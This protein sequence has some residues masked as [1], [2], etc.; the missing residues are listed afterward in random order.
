M[1]TFDSG[2]VGGSPPYTPDKNTPTNTNEPYLSFIDYILSQT[3][4]PRTIT[5]SYGDD[6]QTVPPDYAQDVCNGF[7]KLGVM[8]SSVLFSSGD[9]AVGGDDCLSNDGTNSVKFL[10][11]FP[12]TCTYFIPGILPGS[13]IQIQAHT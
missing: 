11:I 8:G 13:L 5:T 3:S 9:N 2:S 12:A 6:E 10:P 4:I 7:M 1:S